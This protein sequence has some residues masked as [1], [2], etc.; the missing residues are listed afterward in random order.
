MLGVG[1]SL[2]YDRLCSSLRRSVWGKFPPELFNIE[3]FNTTSFRPKMSVLRMLI[4]LIDTQKCILR[5]NHP[6]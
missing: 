2:G 5:G 4:K 1:C 3:S 6:C